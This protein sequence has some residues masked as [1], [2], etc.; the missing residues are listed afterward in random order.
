MSV[1]SLVTRLKLRA[2]GWGDPALRELIQMAQDELFSDSATMMRFVGTNKGFPPYLTTVDGTYKYEIKSAN[3][4]EAVTVTIGGTAYNLVPHKVIKVFQDASGTFYG[5][6][7]VGV[8]TP[9][10]YGSP[11]YIGAERL[12][13]FE[14]PVRSS[15]GTERQPPIIDFFDNPGA[16]TDK[17]FVEFTV[18]PPR[19]T[20]NLIPLMVPVEYERALYDFAMGE[21]QQDENGKLNEYQQKFETYWKPRFLS[22]MNNNA[23][24]IVRDTVIREC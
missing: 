15:I 5:R 19:I 18:L 17:F 16:S 1:E 4:S 14:V 10:R 3:L 9:Y 22:D 8:E 21:I 12:S 23:Q 24:G 13:V 11:F 20:S 7:P 6:T 2:K